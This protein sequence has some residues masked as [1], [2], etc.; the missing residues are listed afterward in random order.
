MRLQCY[1]K[2]VDDLTSVPAEDAWALLKSRRD[3][4]DLLNSDILNAEWPRPRILNQ[5]SPPTPLIPA[6]SNLQ[7][8]LLLNYSKAYPA[9]VAFENPQAIAKSLLNP[10]G[11]HRLEDIMRMKLDLGASDQEKKLKAYLCDPRLQT[12]DISY[13][14]DVPITSEYAAAV[15]SHFLQTEHP[16][17]ALFDPGL[18]VGDLVNK[19]ERFCSRLLV[20]A[21]VA[22][23]IVRLDDT[24]MEL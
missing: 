6:T 22:Y 16:S 3:G 13:W 19:R 20:N 21:L 2:L 11:S 7:T 18:F 17:I 10:S 15:I 8:D 24:R 9:I 14:T 4:V 12:L 1:Q 23:A 5:P